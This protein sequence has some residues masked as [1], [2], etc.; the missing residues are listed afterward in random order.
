MHMRPWLVQQRCLSTPRPLVGGSSRLC[1][2]TLSTLRSSSTS[3][4]TTTTRSSTLPLLPAP[5]TTR[6][7]LLP[8][9]PIYP[10]QTTRHYAASTPTTKDGPLER[11]SAALEARISA[12]PIERYRNFCIQVLDKL[13]VER[14]RGITVKAQTCTMIYNYPKDK[15]DYLLHLVDT[16]GHVDFRAEVTRSYASCGGAILLVDA[17]QGVQ[18]QTVANFYLAFAQGLSLVPV[19]NKVD[20]PTADVE[21]ALG[22]MEEVFELDVSGAVKVSAKTGMGIGEVL[23]AVIERVAHPVGDLGGALRMLL[24]DSWYDTFRGVVLLVRV[25]DGTVRAGDRLVSFATGN[26]YIV[27][28]VGIQYPNQ[29]PQKVLRAGQ[30]GYVF[31][32]PGMKRIQDAKIGDTFTVK[33]REKEVEAYPGFE[34]PK[35]MVFVAAFPTD[36]GDYEKLKES[37]G[38]LV[39]NDRSITL[40]KDHSDALGAG[41]RLGFLGSLHCSVFQDRLRQEYGSD[42]IITEPAVPVKIVWHDGKEEVITNP[43][44]FPDGEDHRLKRSTLYEPMVAATITLPEEYL[45][46]VMELCES[47]RGVQKSV[48]FFSATQVILKYEL[49]TSSLVDDL[50]GKLKGATKGYATLDYEDA[51][52]RESNLVKLNLLVNKEPVDAIARVVHNSQVERLGRQWVTKFKEHV[53]RQMFGIDIGRRRKLLDKQKAGRKRLRSVGNVVIDQSAFQK[54]LTK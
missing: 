30:V 36:Q 5:T 20:L 19:V 1:L 6:S 8:P 29:V 50:F 49:P 12:I 22:Q 31:F 46:R 2:R 17:S 16:P 35:P 15:Q 24:V 26:E 7:V 4:P 14:E 32:N 44:E 41:W 51:G 9:P 40:Q 37:I 13:D 43:A 18:A 47:V 23:P 54:F 42:I 3:R 34:E 52:W 53:D 10:L 11:K 48:E 28:E 27:G 21:R 45:G 38:Q 39:L 33:G 25:F